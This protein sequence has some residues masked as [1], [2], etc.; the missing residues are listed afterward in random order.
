MLQRRMPGRLMG[1]VPLWGGGQRVFKFDPLLT[2]FTPNMD[3]RAA[4]GPFAT[5]PI[6]QGK[7][8]GSGVPDTIIFDRGDQIHDNFYAN[9][10]GY[11]G[12]LSLWWTPEKDRDAGQIDPEYIWYDL[13]GKYH[14]VYEHD[15]QRFSIR[16]GEGSDVGYVAHTSVAGT[17]VHL[18]F[19]WD[20]KNTLDGTNYFS[21]S[22]NNVH[23]FTVSALPTQAT[24]GSSLYIGSEGFFFPANAIIEG[25]TVYR[26]PLFDGTYGVAANWDD[27]GPIDEI[28]AI[29][30]AGAG[31]DPCLI[32]GSWDIV[33][34][35]PTNS[36]QEA[37]ITGTGEAWSHPHS[38]GVLEHQWLEDGGYLGRPW[39]VLYD[40]SDTTIDC[41]SGATLDDMPD[42]ANGFTVDI[43][44]RPDDWGEANTGHLV[45]KYVGDLSGGWMFG[46][47]S[48]NGL[49]AFVFCANIDALSYSGT[50]EFT[51]DGKWHKFTL[52]FHRTANGGDGKIYFAVDG[53]WI[54]SYPSQV[55]GVGA[56]QS[57]AA[58]NFHIGN[59]TPAPSHTQ[60]G[61]V[62]WVHLSDNDRHSHGTDFVPDRQPPA[63]D[64]NSIEMWHLDEG[65]GANIVAEVTSPGNDGT[66][67]NGTWEEQW[68]QETS[69]IVPY[70]VEFD[71]ANTEIDCG[72]GATLDDLADAEMTAE[73]W[74]RTDS[75][76]ESNSGMLF[77]KTGD[78]SVGW[79]MNFH[80]TVGLFA[81][82]Y[83][84]TSHASSRASLAAIPVD[85]KWHHITFYF[86]DAGDRKIYMAVDGL[87][88]SSYGEQT[89]GVGA[90]VSDIAEN[91]YV[92]AN[93]GNWFTCD[94]AIGWVRLSDNDRYSHEVD[95]IPPSRLNPPGVDGNTVEQWDFRDGAGTTLTALVTSPANDSTITPGLGRWLITPDIQVDSPA[96]RIFNWGYVI[97][98]D[99]VDEGILET[100][101]GLTPGE[102]YVVRAV[103]SVESAS[104]GRPKIIIYDETNG[105][106][107]TA[108]EGPSYMGNHDG[109]PGVATLTDTT[110][111][112]PQMLVGWTIYNITDGSS[113]TITAISGDMQTIT[114]ALGGGT[115]ND[116]DIGDEYRIVPPGGPAYYDDYPWIETFTFELPTNER[117][118]VGADCV[119]ISVKLVNGV[120]NGVIKWHQIELLEN[121]LD[122]PSLETGAGNPWIPDGWANAD[123]D[124]GDT[125]A[126]AVVLHSGVGSIEFNAGAI[127]E[128]ISAGSITGVGDGTFFALGGWG[129]GDGDGYLSIGPTGA[130]GEF[131]D[132]SGTRYVT[133]VNS[134]KWNYGVGVERSMAANPTITV[135]ASSGGT[136]DRFL[137]D[138]YMFILDDISLTVT[139]ASLPNSAESGGLRVDGRD[140]LTQPIPAGMLGATSGWIKWK[141]IPRHDTA[142]ADNFGWNNPRMAVF[143]FDGTHYIQ[144]LHI[145]AASLRLLFND[146]GGL[147]QANW[148]PATLNVGTEYSLEIKYN[149][150]QMEFIVDG[151]TQITIVA[152]PNFGAGIPTT[153]WWV[154]GELGIYQV[155]SV[156]KAP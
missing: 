126:E 31:A 93:E 39:A 63:T 90:I 43:W 44:A 112:F 37:L 128:G 96:D 140:T 42:E 81:R 141:Y 108:L 65:T 82:V 122:N 84:A 137:D 67:T 59:S 138:V 123:L 151:V 17:M 115:D 87:W 134:N 12:S 64:G 99:A 148:G 56:Y 24:P 35:L 66:L 145:A 48:A 121:D 105:A 135:V 1:S 68:D 110:A 79:K 71:G 120:N 30:A 7:F 114:G 127:N 143:W 89:A 6:V 142:D 46:L 118:G 41:G 8:D 15:N 102:N 109:G 144:V 21:L 107:I 61:V 116:W 20:T 119:S 91:L 76:G 156:I 92:G 57:D 25:L 73:M 5:A 60:E 125:E 13:S 147:H 131:Q 152:P 27:S 58:V 29:Y 69:P 62:G 83:C 47:D 53:K 40:G 49:F 113:A 4:P 154:S 9:I 3:K 50:D 10:G 18:V 36:T 153:A 75:M 72:S 94:G 86:N 101:V 98:N 78:G 52:F 97:G 95:F 136:G 149:A 55:V 104:R 34:C 100:L 16:A 88:L 14:L 28:E 80:V 150:A 38:S 26:R 106:Q 85:G 124:A 54:S 129:Y 19:R 146:G 132:G 139:P 77:D 133:F 33:F 51:P 22:I 103:A 155:D 32:T 23:T 2:T 111:R 70:S 117:N 45:S 11:Q 74:I 130:N